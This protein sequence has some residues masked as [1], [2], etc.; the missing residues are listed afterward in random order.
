MV[1]FLLSI[2]KYIYQHYMYSKYSLRQ[3]SVSQNLNCV[4]DQFYVI[5]FGMACF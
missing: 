3:T 5:Y 1:P 2:M 4:S